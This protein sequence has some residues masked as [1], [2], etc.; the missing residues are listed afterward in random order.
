MT[1]WTYNIEQFFHVGDTTIRVHLEPHG[2]VSRALWCVVTDPHPTGA[3]L[4]HQRTGSRLVASQVDLDFLLADLGVKIA[5][6]PPTDD[7]NSRI[8]SDA[9]V[10]PG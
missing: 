10:T 1:T 2:S 5:D 7:L 6:V 9:A 4:Q 3:A 8:L